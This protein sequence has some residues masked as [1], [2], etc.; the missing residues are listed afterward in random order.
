MFLQA[1]HY[2]TMAMELSAGTGDSTGVLC[3]H[4]QLHVAYVAL[5]KEGYL[6]GLGQGLGHGLG[7]GLGTLLLENKTTTS[8]FA[9]PASTSVS[10]VSVR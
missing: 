3:P 5:G 10:W 2:H 7:R 6:S 1:L 4:C 9:F 8:F